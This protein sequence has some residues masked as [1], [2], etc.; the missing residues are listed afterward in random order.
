[1]A[2]QAMFAREF[3]NRT[4]ALNTDAAAACAEIAV[5]RRDLRVIW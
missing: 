3:H 2:A 4:L 5:A 1:M